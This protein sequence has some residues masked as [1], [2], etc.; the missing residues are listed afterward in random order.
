MPA[1]CDGCNMVIQGKNYLCC[2]ACKKKY[3]LQCAGISTRKFTLMTEDDKRNWKC[4]ECVSKQPKSD[5][6]NTPLRTNQYQADTD[7]GEES[8]ECSNI[9]K[10]KVAGKAGHKKQ[11][12][13]ERGGIEQS[14]TSLKILIKDTF[15][16]LFSHDLNSIKKQLSEFQEAFKFF[17]QVVEDLKKE[18]DVLK[19]GN[20]VISNDLKTIK[21]EN[22]K[23]KQSLKSYETRVKKLEEDNSRQQ[24]WARLQ[25]VEIVGV[26]E[27]KEEVTVEVA[28]KVMSCIGVPLEPRDIE[29]AHRVQPRRTTSAK[30]GRAI[31]VRLKDRA[32][33]DKI[34]TAA[35]TRR[36]MSAVEMGF[37]GENGFIY[38]N[39]HLT[40]E[41]KALIVA[42]K[43]KAK[44]RDYKY[45]WTK[46]CRIF[47]RRNDTSPPMPISSM[48]DLEKIV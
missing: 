47:M 25:N 43:T 46:N 4:T 5:N 18:N 19:K 29:F 42:C 32:I 36:N 30:R 23:L 35:R 1:S 17:N 31:V 24:Q 16:E 39:E 38:I 3:E 6:T 2:P 26:P 34:I 11:E 8:V 14:A 20:S 33:R 28:R 40:I 13:V 7:T 37:G 45:V 9:T 48:A 15:T 21:E 10:R 41:N 12:L 44:E 27:C 22:V